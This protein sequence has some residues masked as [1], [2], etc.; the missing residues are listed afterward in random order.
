[1][2]SNQYKTKISIELHTLAR[3]QD[4]GISAAEV[5]E[6]LM[7]GVE[8]PAKKGRFAKFKVFPFNRTIRGR[9]YQQL[10]LEV[11]YVIE[12]DQ[13]FTVTIYARY[14]VWED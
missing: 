10:R 6:V 3:M 13:I 12:R 7:T 2:V 9:T 8:F 14:G 1:M 4:Y 11:I 5:E